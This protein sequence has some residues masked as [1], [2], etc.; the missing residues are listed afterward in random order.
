MGQKHA[1]GSS[2]LNKENM[3]VAPVKAEKLKN[4]ILTP[5]FPLSMHFVQNSEIF[6]EPN[7]QEFGR[8]F[9]YLDFLLSLEKVKKSKPQKIKKL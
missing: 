7:V 3:T 6:P 8:K 5:L 4:L 9:K 2:L 1:E